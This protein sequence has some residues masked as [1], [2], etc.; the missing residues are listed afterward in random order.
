MRSW[1]RNLVLLI[2]TV[3]SV[4]GCRLPGRESGAAGELSWPYEKPA[5]KSLRGPI[6]NKDGIVVAQAGLWTK[7]TDSPGV[8]SAGGRLAFGTDNRFRPGPQVPPQP[9]PAPTPWSGGS[10]PHQRNLPT[11]FGDRL[12]LGPGE[13]P[14]E[15]VVELTR[16]LETVTLHNRSLIDRLRQLEAQSQTR[17]QALNEAV[18]QVEAATQEVNRARS[19]IELLQNEVA[20]LQAQIRQMEKED[21]ELLRA[22]IQAL[23][24]LLGE[25]RGP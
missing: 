16:E 24:R 10:D 7:S 25:R 4:S 22:V 23:E 2:A 1:S 5:G 18:R 21:V 3:G 15:R 14:L 9:L 20:T 17:E 19:Q 11:V 13:N 12:E 8:V 6:D